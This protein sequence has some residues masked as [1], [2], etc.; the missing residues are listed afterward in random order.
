MSEQHKE[1]WEKCLEIIKDN[2]NLQSFKTWFK[3]IEAIK[4]E[5]K[6]L[7]IQVPSLFFYEWLEEHYVNL[8]R[9]TIKKVIGTGAKLEYNIVVET[10]SGNKGQRTINMP[11]SQL[12]KDDG[13][14]VS[15]P[16]NISN[17]IK[18]PFIIPG[19]KKVKVDPQLNNNFIFDHFIEG[20]CNRLAR[21][22]GLAVASKPGGTSFNPFLSMEAWV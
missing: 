9:R 8:L 21:S 19:L 3:P 15:M 12:N 17:S 16:L 22:A 1:V 6:V 14:E 5:A 10:S 13:M 2:V 11:A 18:N 7:T 4:L 20:E